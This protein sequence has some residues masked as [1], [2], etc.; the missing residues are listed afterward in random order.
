MSQMGRS[1]TV[2][3]DLDE[4]EI[5]TR[6]HKHADRVVRLRQSKALRFEGDTVDPAVDSPY[7]ADVWTTA[8]LRFWR[9][10]HGQNPVAG[11]P[12]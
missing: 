9:M 2:K 10:S 3:T 8:Y 5:R 12:A 11:P 7:W 1:I 4:E 6:A